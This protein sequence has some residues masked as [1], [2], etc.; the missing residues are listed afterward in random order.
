LNGMLRW[1]FDFESDNEQDVLWIQVPRTAT[2]V[3]DLLDDRCSSEEIDEKRVILS[4]RY[5]KEVKYM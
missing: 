4:D 2:D 1:S 3:Q 5:S